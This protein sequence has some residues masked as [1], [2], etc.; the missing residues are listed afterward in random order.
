MQMKKGFSLFMAVLVLLSLTGCGGGI[1]EEQYRQVCDERDALKEE[2]Q[3]LKSTLSSEADM[4]Q[5]TISGT[6][7]ATVRDL[8][9]DYVTDDATPAMAVVT[10][11][12]CPPFLIYTGEF[13]EQLETGET[14]VFEIRP[15]VLE[16]T[17]EEYEINAPDPEI[18][19]P[20]YNLR[21]AG[22][23][24]SVESDWGLD[25]VHLVYKRN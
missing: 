21:L 4:M 5:V 7:T 8:I 12:Q 3:E 19:F 9:P 22:F 14:Y 10:L 11:F 23:R 20:E 6:F 18:V 24:E 15:E 2:L 17:A 25:S 1:T 16:I 13:T